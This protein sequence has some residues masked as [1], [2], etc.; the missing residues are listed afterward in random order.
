MADIEDAKNHVGI[1]IVEL[2][3]LGL[4]RTIGGWDSGKTRTPLDRHRQVGDQGDLPC[5]A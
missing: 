4:V 1:G 2:S 5:F 3:I